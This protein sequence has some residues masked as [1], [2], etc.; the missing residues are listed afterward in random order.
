MAHNVSNAYFS[1][2]RQIK[3]KVREVTK[4]QHVIRVYDPLLAYKTRLTT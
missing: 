4:Y 1:V 2:T 3:Y